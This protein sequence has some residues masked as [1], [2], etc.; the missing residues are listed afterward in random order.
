MF[1]VSYQPDGRSCFELGINSITTKIGIYFQTRNDSQIR[2][3]VLTDNRDDMVSL[4][5][6]KWILDFN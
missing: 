6:Q 5:L 1:K 4:N 2:V 3:S